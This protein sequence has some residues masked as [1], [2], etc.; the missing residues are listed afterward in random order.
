[1]PADEAFT[2]ACNLYSQ[3][4][5]VSADASSSGQ[6]DPEESE[7]SNEDSS[8]VSL[9]GL[10]FLVL[11]D[12]SFIFVTLTCWVHTSC[13]TMHSMERNQKP[14]CMQDDAS[15]LASSA[16]SEDN[17]EQS[18]S[19]DN[20]DADSNQAEVQAVDT[21]DTLHMTPNSP[22]LSA[23]QRRQLRDQLA[24]QLDD[25]RVQQA[26]QSMNMIGI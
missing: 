21:C 25:L 19:S 6:Q 26:A 11:Q 23:Q 22:A 8:E 2:V 16:V 3:L 20:D 18:D 4:K 15:S 1:M 17:S 7:T 13:C 12:W 5:S 14:A 9:S 10:C 24:E